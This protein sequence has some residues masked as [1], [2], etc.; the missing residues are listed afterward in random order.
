MRGMLEGEDY[1]AVDMVIST[2]SAY[3][4]CVTG[5]QNDSNMINVSHMCSD[6]FSEEVS[7]NCSRG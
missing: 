5:I 6:I 1:R 3:T 2:R 7:E 4:D